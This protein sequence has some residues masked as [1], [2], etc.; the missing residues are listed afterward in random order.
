[1]LL[2]CSIEALKYSNNINKLRLSSLSLNAFC[3][4]VNLYVKPERRVE[5]L[6]VIAGN[7]AGSRTLEPK[8]KLYVWGESTTTAN[9]FHFQEIYDDE[10]GFKQHTSS[11]HFAKWAAFASTSPFTK[12][13]EV[14]FFNEM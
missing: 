6:E 3:L 1:M 7:A 4:N 14:M 5:F 2:I 12:E 11:Q 9:L 13:P 10:D 8:C